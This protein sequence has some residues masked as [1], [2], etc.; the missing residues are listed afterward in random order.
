[1]TFP[2]EKLDGTKEN[3]WARQMSTSFPRNFWNRPQQGPSTR[4]RYGVKIRPNRNNKR[5]GAD[6]GI[7]MGRKEKPW[8]EIAVRVSR[9]AFISPSGFLHRRVSIQLLV[10]FTPR[11]SSRR[12]H[13]S[14]GNWSTGDK[15]RCKVVLFLSKGISSGRRN[16]VSRVRAAKGTRN[17]AELSIY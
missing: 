11:I 3:R 6:R 2:V 14:I 1:M 9:S 16:I 13:G 7:G 12:F 8:R 5:R 10:F 17:C 4:G 15:D